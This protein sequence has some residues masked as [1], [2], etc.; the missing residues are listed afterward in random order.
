MVELATQQWGVVSV[1]Q[2]RELGL[3]RGA[4]DHG[5]GTG[6]LRRLH[7][8]VYAVGH[9]ALRR[10][11]HWLAAVLACGPGAVL[12]HHDAAA[13][14]GIR[15]R[16]LTTV[17]VS[18]PRTRH[19]QEGIALHRPR[20]LAQHDVTTK[21]GIPTTTPERTLRDLKA[22]LPVAAYERTAARAERQR[23]VAPA[24]TEP[25]LTESEAE[26]RLLERIRRAG[27]PEPEVNVWLADVGELKVDFLWRAERLVVEIDGF[28]T[29]GTRSAFEADRARD[30]QL[31][32]AGYRV[33]RFT[34]RQLDTAAAAIRSSIAR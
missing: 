18:A 6:R 32:G 23:L 24:A 14:W 1:A 19:G 7:R 33:L 4:I 31:V 28:A 34:W 25:K 10:E 30:R 17:H 29:H 3:G 15:Q 21:D 27:L 22:I 11:G 12:S 26:H 2:L 9:T 13:L 8:G 5:A 16:S 20:S